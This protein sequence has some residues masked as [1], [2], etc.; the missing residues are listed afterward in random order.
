ME[1]RKWDKRG[2]RAWLPQTKTPTSSRS[3]HGP[4]TNC[5]GNQ[6]TC[7]CLIVGFFFYRYRKGFEL[8][9]T[10]YSGIN[11]AVLLIVAGQQFENSMEL[12]KIGDFTLYLFFLK[13]VCIIREIILIWA[14]QAFLK[15][16][17]CSCRCQ[18]EQPAGPQRFSGENEQLLGCGAVLYG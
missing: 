2:R 11:L 16:W 18:V 17:L 10:L 4:H 9:P 14:L 12:R 7:S 13:V 8:Q 1:C 6:I 3:N 15:R 5:A